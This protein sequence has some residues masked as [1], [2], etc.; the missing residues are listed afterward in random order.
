MDDYKRF[1][2]LFPYQASSL[3]GGR[4]EETE[5]AKTILIC[6]L[7]GGARTDVNREEGT[8]SE[9]HPQNSSAFLGQALM[10]AAAVI[11]LPYISSVWGSICLL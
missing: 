4:G 3:G 7:F 1:L 5:R 11:S 9:D 8:Q 10:R 6:R 2:V